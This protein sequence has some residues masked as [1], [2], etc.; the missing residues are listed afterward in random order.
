MISKVKDLMAIGGKLDEISK[1]VDAAEESVS[2]HSAEIAEYRKDVSGLKEDFT[3]LHKESSKFGSTVSDQIDALKKAREDLENELYDFKRIKADIKA[4][5][6]TELTDDFREELKKETKK[7]DTDVKQFNELKDEL[8]SLV[9]EFKSVEGEIAKFRK[10]AGQVK[11]AD[12]QLAR[13]AREL[14]KADQEKLNLMQKVDQLERLISKMRR[15][16]P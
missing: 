11:E 10:I 4:K 6:V 7:L 9:T 2:M 16:R 13:H 3:G 1:K 12:F 15:G 14:T 8:S 5:L